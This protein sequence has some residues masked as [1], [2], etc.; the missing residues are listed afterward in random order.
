LLR[1]GSLLHTLD[2]NIGIKLSWEDVLHI[3]LDIYYI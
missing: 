2:Q 3:K 1:K